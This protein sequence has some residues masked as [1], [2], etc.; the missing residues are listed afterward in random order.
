M[1]YSL[2]KN[3]L[4]FG[5]IFIITLGSLFYTPFVNTDIMLDYE[6]IIKPLININSLSDYF[7][8]IKVGK[9]HDF[10][11]IRDLSHRLD[12]FLIEYFKFEKIA[13]L[14][15]ILILAFTCL[16]L[17]KTLLY[18]FEDKVAFY[19][20][21]LF[22]VHPLTF[23]IYVSIT[24]RKHILSFLFF[25]ISYFYFLNSRKKYI[26]YTSYFLS[27]FS[28]PINVFAPLFFL[29]HIKKEKLFLKKNILYFVPY[30]LIFASGVILNLYYYE[31]FH[32]KKVG[33]SNMQYIYI[34]SDIFNAIAVH[35]RQFFW[36]FSFSTYYTFDKINIFISLI[37]APIFCMYI[38]KI[39]R[40]VFKKFIVLLFS[41]FFILYGHKS[42]VLSVLIQDSY[43]LTPSFVFLVFIG[44]IWKRYGS[45]FEYILIPIILFSFCTS[46]YF[47][48]LRTNKY[49]YYQHTLKTESH[50]RVQQFV[51]EEAI[52]NNLQ[53]DVLTYG[54]NW[55]NEKCNIIGKD[56]G[57]RKAFINT[58][59][60]FLSSDFTV[61]EKISLFIKK[62]PNKF[63][64]VQI[65]AAL[66]IENKKS[67]ELIN[68]YLIQLIDSN[69]SS[70]FTIKSFFKES[71]M[72]YCTDNKQ[73]GCLVFK[74][75]LARIDGK[76][77][78][79][80]YNKNTEQL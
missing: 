41:I 30:L 58:H 32:Y 15:N 40:S 74:D 66:L 29:T 43:L 38:Y 53:Q 11:P 76:N 10:Q 65:I 47:S 19:L 37:S 72:I 21:S 4:F 77:M 73:E 51:V 9:I 52:S 26:S 18:F 45:K 62:F 24:N 28:Q 13:L 39:N 79:I 44:L 50:C 48:S 57:Y 59:L 3:K 60:V 46:L 56:L 70:V 20:V 68:K 54:M 34:Y 49:N 1:N 75:Y 67:P 33:L 36:P 5:F 14:H 55:L 17:F 23:H 80:N 6:I 8:Q 22:I 64:H 63:D 31:I 61:D 35:F 2:H 12:L 7:E 16:I 78:L 27:L 42:N 25:M 71:I 69:S